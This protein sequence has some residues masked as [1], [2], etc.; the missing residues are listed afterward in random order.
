MDKVKG[1][2]IYSIGGWA[3]VLRHTSGRSKTHYCTLVTVDFQVP[4]CTGL[5][6]LV[7]VSLQSRLSIPPLIHLN[8]KIYLYVV[9]KDLNSTIDVR[10]Y[11]FIYSIKR[12]GP[13]TEPWGTPLSTGR[14]LLNRPAT[15]T[16]IVRLIKKHLIHSKTML[17]IPNW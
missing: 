3:S 14:A 6:Q 17:E 8:T 10:Y 9:G 15:L 16:F 12:M 11:I 13:R 4:G 1:G 2:T 7:D 5:D